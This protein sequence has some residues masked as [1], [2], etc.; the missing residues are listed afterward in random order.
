MMNLIS[1]GEWKSIKLEVELK[2]LFVFGSDF[3]VI[4]K[5]PR[6]TTFDFIPS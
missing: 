6:F 5:S 3:P 4:D 2:E 1:A